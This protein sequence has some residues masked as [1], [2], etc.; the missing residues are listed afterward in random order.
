MAM[1]FRRLAA[2]L[3][4]ILT[5]PAW[6]E[7]SRPSA[8]PVGSRN[9]N[10]TLVPEGAVALRCVRSSDPQ[11]DL[12]FVQSQSLSTLLDALPVR[13]LLNGYEPLTE[14]LVD[15][16]N[17]QYLGTV[18]V[19]SPGQE[20]TMI[21]DTGSSDMW[22]DGRSFRGGVSQT[23]Q[24]PAADRCDETV[25]IDYSVGSV[26]GKLRTDRLTIAGWSV[27]KQMFVLVTAANGFG[28]VYFQGVLGLAFPLLSHSGGNTVLTHLM[29]ETHVTVFS[30][31]LADEA[32]PSEFLFGLP[33]ESSFKTGTLTYVPVALQEWWTL[34][35]SMAIGH[36][37]L[38]EDSLFALD[39]GTSYLTV[40]VAY[41]GAFLK[42]LLPP[43]LMQQCGRQEL[44]KQYVCP[45]EVRHKAKVVY[46]LVG[47][48]EFPIFPEDMFKRI[49]Q[50]GV[51]VMEVQPSAD[52]MPFILGDTFLRTI[53]AIFDAGR[54]RIGLAQRSG[55][56][57]R[58][59]STRE[60][61]LEDASSPRSRPLMPP[62]LVASD[63]W[64]PSAGALLAAI[65]AGLC[66]GYMAGNL[67]LSSCCCCGSTEE[68][69]QRF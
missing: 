28:N 26:V 38:C 51:C 52:A 12:P 23:L 22:V 42:T 17:V 56:A 31:L 67:F 57:P 21:F 11:E 36:T 5:L 69:Y 43:Q 33:P 7:V 32:E 39:T 14:P 6:S 25:T 35:G 64:T 60:R 29:G 4:A 61:L 13:A 46:M 68:A 45:C 66:A 48:K 41:F 44:T 37:V 55:H 20:V 30:F 40:P 18:Q 59:A 1:M 8:L 10:D 15:L 34:K 16:A 24:C 63:P 53:A 49:G 62:H 47:G 27:A 9:R 50:T 3:G 19:G 2:A 65:L 54:L 58:L